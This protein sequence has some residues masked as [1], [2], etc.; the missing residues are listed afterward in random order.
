V[1]RPAGH[2]DHLGGRHLCSLPLGI[3]LALGRQSKLPIIKT[4]CICSSS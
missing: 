1:G 2:A 4:L 3:L